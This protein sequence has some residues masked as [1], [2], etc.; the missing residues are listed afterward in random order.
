MMDSTENSRK[1]VSVVIPIYNEE[2]YIENCI[3]SLIRQDY[4]RENMEWIL[5][6]GASIDRTK[7]IIK[8]FMDRFKGLIK[9]YNN[10]NK[11]VPYAMNIGIKAAA[12]K[13]II[14]LDAH[15][16]YAE[17]YISKC[18]YYL[19]TTDADNVGGVAETRSSGPKGK[20]VSLMLSSK[21]GVGSSKFRTNGKSSYVD[22][23]PFGAFHKEVFEKYGLYDVRLTRNEDNEMNYRIR[24]NGGKIY[25]AQDIKFVYYCRDSIKGIANMAVQNGKWNIITMKLCPGA[26]GV[27]H[28]IP[29]MFL[30][31]LIILP[32]LTAFM[33]CIG[34]LL[35]LEIGLYVM[36][37]I[38]FSIKAAGE[39][40]YIPLLLTLFPIFHISYGFG[41][42]TGM[43]SIINKET[44]RG[45]RVYSAG[46]CGHFGKNKNYLD[47]QTVKTKELTRELKNRLGKD[48][49]Y[50]VDTYRWK[51]N[52]VFIIIKCCSLMKKCK[53][54]IIMP[55]DNGI[56][57]FAPLFLLLNKIFHRKLHYVVIGGWLRELLEKKPKLKNRLSRFDGIYVETKSMVKSLEELGLSNVRHLPNFK[58]LQIL[59]ESQLVYPACE[60]YKLCTFSRVLK[61]KGIEDAIDAVKD[62]NTLLGK[63]AYTLDIYGQIDDEYYERFKE[64][65]KEFPKY[66]SYKGCVKFSSSVNALKDYFALLFPT[67]YEYEGFAGTILDAFASGVPVIATSWKYNSEIIQNEIDGLIYD[68]RKPELLKKILS[69]TYENPKLITN[70]KKNCLKR[71]KEYSPEVVIESLMLFF[72]ER[73]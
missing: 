64:I 34:Y 15:S 52:A 3:L 30:L 57:V 12:G 58:S 67:Y 23:V 32:I 18:V 27:R 20:A 33:S 59:K 37:D 36:L 1:I 54:V 46:V 72:R 21:F 24:K 31:S 7:E 22:T 28:F 50:T 11:T 25:M 41:S 51:L 35:M 69:D 55:G 4:P 48:S 47:G 71:A 13:Y 44:V 43:I 6:D 63:T 56:K 19:E 62:V 17:N 40:K 38:I 14:R 42:L 61:E 16:E 10:P 60:P 8:N 70:M 9:L 39:L 45:D 26:M 49:I 66:I 73:N 68:Y 53:D 65:E 29:F 2:N 5:V